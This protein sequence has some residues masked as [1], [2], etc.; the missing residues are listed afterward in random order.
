MECPIPPNCHPTEDR[1]PRVLFAALRRHIHAGRGKLC[2][3]SMKTVVSR[4]ISS[5]RQMHGSNRGASPTTTSQASNQPQLNRPGRFVPLKLPHRAAA[6]PDR[7]QGAAN[8]A[9]VSHSRRT[10]N[11]SAAAVVEDALQWP[12]AVPGSLQDRYLLSHQSTAAWQSTSLRQIREHP[13]TG[14]SRRV[15]SWKMPG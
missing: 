6:V 12:S 14:T 9:Q 13:L 3:S 10:V 7:N 15:L 11:R 5:C 1:A 8:S 4:R 2:A